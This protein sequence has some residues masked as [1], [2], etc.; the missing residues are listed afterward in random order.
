RSSGWLYGYGASGEGENP[1]W[2]NHGTTFH[3]GTEGAADFGFGDGGFVT[4]LEDDSDY[5]AFYFKKSFAAPSS[6]YAHDVLRLYLRVDDGAVVHLNAGHAPEH[7]FVHYVNLPT[8]AQ[9]AARPLRRVGNATWQA[10]DIPAA[11]LIPG[12]SENVLAV[13]VHQY[14]RPIRADHSCV[15]V[16]G[17]PAPG[18]CSCDPGC[19]AAG[20]C[21]ADDQVACVNDAVPDALASLPAPVHDPFLFRLLVHVDESGQARLLKEVIQMTRP[22]RVVR[23]PQPDGL[24]RVEVIEPLEYVLL[25][26]PQRIPDF[27]PVTFVDG[28]PVGRR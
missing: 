14:E 3:T 24:D 10:I 5:E 27:E 26:D 17:G 11:K 25:T 23:T 19:E 4:E 6:I 2:P 28:R 20:T 22:G 15:G 9:R 7:Q 18:G 8:G 12:S 1:A 21:C 13:R 16:C